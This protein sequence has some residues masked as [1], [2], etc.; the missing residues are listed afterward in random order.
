[1]VQQG[2]VA[3]DVQRGLIKPSH[4]CQFSQVLELME[5]G[6]LSE[7]IKH[8]ADGRADLVQQGPAHRPGHRPRP[9]TTSTPTM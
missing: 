6:D 4:A 1:M 8:D 5:G 3:L 2:L 7:A 9:D